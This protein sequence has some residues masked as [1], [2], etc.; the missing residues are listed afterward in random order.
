MSSRSSGVMNTRSS[1]RH[2]VVGHLVGLVLEPLDLVH[3]HAAPVGVGAQQVLLQPGGLH[4]EGGDRREQVEEL[5]VA[6]QEPHCHIQV[7]GGGKITP[8]PGRP[9]SRSSIP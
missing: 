8:L 1:R 9:H 4:R 7:T 5:L 2:H 6:G 3:D